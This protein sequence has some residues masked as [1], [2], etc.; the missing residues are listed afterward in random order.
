MHAHDVGRRGDFAGRISPLNAERL[1]SFRAETAAPRHHSHP[2]GF[3]ARY[4]LAADAAHSEQAQRAAADPPSLGEFGLV[5]LAGAERDDV[6][7]D[8]PVEGQN[9]REGQLRH[10]HRVLSGAVGDVDAA[11]RGRRQI[12]GIVAGARA[13]HQL[14][15]PGRQHR[16][17]DPG[18]AHDQHIRIELG[19]ARGERLVLQSG[20]TGYLAPEPGQAVQPGLLELVRHEYSHRPPPLYDCTSVWRCLRRPEGWLATGRRGAAV[21]ARAGR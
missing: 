18:G 10:R 21:E 9:Q 6:V 11:A 16:L 8:A 14:E 13:D 3:G 15:R 4:H 7:R 1:C 19:D 12:D 2:K 20:F 17:A 5:P